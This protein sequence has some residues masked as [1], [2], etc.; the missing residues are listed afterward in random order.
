MDGAGA[1]HEGVLSGI[2]VL[3]FGR[4]IAGPF[5][6]ALL[7]DHGADVIR[8]DKVGGSEDRCILPLAASGEGGL[9]MQ[10][11]RGKRSLALDPGVVEGREIVRRLIG[12]SDVVIANMP[13]ATL[14]SMGLDYASVS[15][16]NPRVILVATNAFGRTGPY[17]HRLGFDGLGQALSGTAYMTGDPGAPRRAAVNWVDFG[18]AISA[19]FGTLL[20]LMARE[21]SGRGQEVSGSLMATAL[22]FANSVLIE[23]AINKP[24]RVPQGNLGY[25]SAPADLFECGDGQWLIVQAVG[26]PLWERFCTMLGATD[27]LADPR[28]ADDSGRG[29]HAHVVSERLGAWCAARSR[30]EAILA[31]EA[32]RIPAGPVHSPQQALEDAHVR[33]SGMLREIAFPGAPR[34]APVAETPVR[35]SATPGAIRGRAP[36]LGEH[37]E[38]ILAEIGYPPEHVARLR[39]AGVV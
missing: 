35:L 33:A 18:T 11:N 26:Q 39:D 22:T 16:I 4:F 20:A 30:D 23:Q 31:F 28:F 37:T 34:S 12:R 5:C 14:Q 25:G 29:R 38:A 21:R 2:R 27:W 3:D 10:V 8:V 15:A 36:L 19:A 13:A 17:A 32:A 9:Y 7:A 24:D 6:G 1:T